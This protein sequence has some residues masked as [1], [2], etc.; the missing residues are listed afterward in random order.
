MS[1]IILR[2]RWCDIIALNFHAPIEDKIDDMKERFL[3]EQVYDKFPYYQMKF[4][5]GDFSA[6]VDRE[7]ISNPTI[8]NN[9][10]HETS[11]KI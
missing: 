11:N 3:E 8:G 10:L 4:F 2:S 9:S 1:Y 6:K 5:L 7:G